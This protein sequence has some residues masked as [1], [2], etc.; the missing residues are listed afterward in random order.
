MRDNSS[1]YASF[2]G[3]KHCKVI[4]EISHGGFGQVFLI[5]MLNLPKN[6]DAALKVFNFFGEA[7]NSLE[8]EQEKVT[9]RYIAMYEKHMDKPLQIAHI[10]ED[11]NGVVCPNLM[12]EYLN[13]FDMHSNVLNEYHFP[14]LL[15]FV[16]NLMD[17]IGIGVLNQLHAMNVYHND[18]KPDNI[19]FD[20][21]TQLFYLI[22]F[23]L[24]LP[25]SF[26]WRRA[27][28][29]KVK[30]LT[31]LRFNSP[32]HLKIMYQSRFIS[33]IDGRT[34]YHIRDNNETRI[35][36][37]NADFYSF[38]LSIIRILGMHCHG[39]DSLCLM[40]QRIV[41]LQRDYFS[42]FDEQSF[43]RWSVEVIEPIFIPYWKQIHG[44]IAH[45]MSVYPGENT[46]FMSTLYNWLHPLLL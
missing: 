12:L 33:K 14:I 36:A 10:R 5:E 19:M 37:I 41:L 32:W 43:V 42:A 29:Q 39:N 38:G 25:L 18:L 40:S 46:I 2:E 13:G 34:K 35:Y 7:R 31:T 20:P 28:F 21:Q 24:A 17:Q 30:Y 44:V 6:Q 9:L 27:T 16:K 45:Y 4:K 23:G 3:I 15:E 1:D 8:C 26:N 11:I 22:D